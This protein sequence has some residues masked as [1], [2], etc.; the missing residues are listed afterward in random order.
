[1]ASSSSFLSSFLLLALVIGA[2]SATRIFGLRDDEDAD[3]VGFRSEAAQD[4]FEEYDLA[5][6]DA[7]DG[8]ERFLFSSTTSVTVNST[9]L[10][11]IGAIIGAL[12]I[13]LP[14]Y[15][16]YAT[17]GSGGGGGGSAGGY[18]SH[19][20]RRYRRDGDE[21]MFTFSFRSSECEYGGPLGNGAETVWGKK[22]K[23]N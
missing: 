12:L 4:R 15:L 18:G 3:Q 8:E 19:R 9:L 22:I 2:S 1:M 11:A 13:A 16:A 5:E 7:E 6:G 17:A 21:G 20:K 10:R 23:Y 14:L